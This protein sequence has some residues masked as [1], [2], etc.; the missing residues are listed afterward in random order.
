MADMIVDN[1]VDQ[2]EKEAYK[3]SDQI[4]E[5]A[6]LME[7]AITNEDKAVKKTLRNAAKELLD[8]AIKRFDESIDADIEDEDD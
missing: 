5:A 1:T 7:H 6:R 8:N 2:K 3:I 4:H